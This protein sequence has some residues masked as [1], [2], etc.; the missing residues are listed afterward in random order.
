MEVS[1]QRN[2]PIAPLHATNNQQRKI[3]TIES[4]TFI[5]NIYKELNLNNLIQCMKCHNYA[6]ITCQQHDE[7]TL[8]A[9]LDLMNCSENLDFLGY[10]C[11]QCKYT[12][13]LLNLIYEGTEKNLKDYQALEQEYQAFKQ[14]YQAFKQIANSNSNDVQYLRDRVAMPRPA[15]KPHPVK[16]VEPPLHPSTT[17]EETEDILVRK[18]PVVYKEPVVCKPS[19]VPKKYI[20][21]KRLVCIGVP[22][23]MDDTTF[24]Q[25]IS[26]ELNLVLDENTI[27]KTFRINAKNISA[28][29]SQPLNIELYHTSDKIKLLSQDTKDKIANL[30]P[31]SKF[32]G[33]KF[34]PDRPYKH[35]KKYSELKTEMD[36]RNSKLKSRNLNT[37][38]WVIR[39]MSLIKVI[40]LGGVKTQ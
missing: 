29:K 16:K 17:S 31:H 40:T 8:S 7:N 23:E 21:R 6:D 11:K 14:D 3:E 1:T 38:K 9:Y 26:Q 35:R 2:T 37:L 34:F 22:R 18:E 27:K 19:V 32:H 15:K 4:N 24:M 13:E 36:A 33:V 12:D 5:H 25:E 28:D 20:R 10:I 30:P 39:N